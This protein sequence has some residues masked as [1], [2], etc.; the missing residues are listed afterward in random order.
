MSAPTTAGVAPPAPEVQVSIKL[1]LPVDGT[2][3]KFKLPLRDLVAPVFADKVCRLLPHL[4]CLMMMS[5]QHLLHQIRSIIQV[6]DN[7]KLLLE[8]FS[9]SGNAFVPLETTNASAYKQLYRAGKAKQKLKLRATLLTSAAPSEPQQTLENSRPIQQTARFPNLHTH[10]HSQPQEPKKMSGIASAG[11]AAFFQNLAEGST[12]LEEQFKHL[13]N[14][15]HRAAVGGVW[16]VFCNNCDKPMKDAHFHCS[17][18]DDGDYDLCQSCVTAG[19]GCHGEEHWL[20]KRFIADGKVVNSTTETIAPRSSKVTEAPLKPDVPTFKAEPLRSTPRRMENRTKIDVAS[21]LNAST[22]TCNACVQGKQSDVQ[23]SEPRLTNC[24]V[25]PEEQFLTCADCPDVDFCVPCL[26]K[27]DL[28][29]HPGHSFKPA[30]QGTASTFDE[31][32]HSLSKANRNTR[33]AALC[34]DCDK[35]SRITI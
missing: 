14:D 16:Q 28:G 1:S 4:I 8:R 18:C 24:I 31:E 11:R 25:L 19:A 33:H 12:N 35:V 2:N 17:I 26:K 30:V 27:N 9:D 10:S 34:D 23:K 3:R 22:R 21:L 15:T 13:M 29:H 5:D 7:Q 6:P 32:V 20:I